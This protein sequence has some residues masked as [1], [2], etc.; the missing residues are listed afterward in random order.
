[1]TMPSKIWIRSRVP[2]T[3][4]ACTLTVSPGI[5]VGTFLRWDSASSRLMTLDTAYKDIT[6]LAATPGGR[7]SP[8]GDGGSARRP[9]RAAS[10]RSP[11]GGPSATPRERDAL[12]IRR[13]G[14]SGGN[15]GG[16]ARRDWPRGVLL[17]PPPPGRA[18]SPHPCAP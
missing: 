3:T 17:R 9:G 7:A 5:K 4:L 15:R 6:P 1:M 10:G 11:H 18:H 2:S 8:G 13:G 14:G 16:G 12:R